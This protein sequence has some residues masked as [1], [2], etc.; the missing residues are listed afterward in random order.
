MGEGDLAAVSGLRVDKYLVTVGRFRQF[1]A[2]WN[3]GAGYTPPATSGKH[4]HLNGGSGLNATGGGFEPGWVT[5]DNTN[6]QPTNGNLA[7]DP[8]HATWTAT[9]GSNEKLPI[10]CVNWWESYAFCIWDGGFL[11]S[12][13]EWEYVAAGGSDQREYPWGA[14]APGTTNQYAIYGGNASNGIAPVG[15]ATLGAGKWGQLD[16]AGELWEWTLDWNAPYVPCTDCANFTTA[17]YRVIRGGGFGTAASEV[18][19]PFRYRDSPSFRGGGYGFRC[20]RT[21]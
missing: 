3:N 5:T 18:L 17:S 15:T 2:A 4:A 19:P 9:A 14:T 10:N 20:A 21:P 6:I 7:C 13:A 12:E 16:L 11:P 8:N 1:V